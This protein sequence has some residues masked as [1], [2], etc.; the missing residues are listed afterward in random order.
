MP[1]EIYI[2]GEYARLYGFDWERKKAIYRIARE[3]KAIYI[4]IDIV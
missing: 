4:A 1:K 2:N 3:Q